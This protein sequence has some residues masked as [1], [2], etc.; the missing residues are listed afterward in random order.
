MKG[1]DVIKRL[2]K[3]LPQHSLL[4]IHKSFTRPHLDYGDILYEQPNKTFCQKIETSQ[5]NAA[6]AITDAIKGTSQIKL[7]NELGLESLA[8]RQWFRQ[9]CLFYMIKKNWFTRISIQY[10]I[11]KHP[12]VQHLVN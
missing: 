8:F 7:Y 1:K 5:Y 2:S 4:I 11:T 3:M 10:D 12:S 6:L 9:L